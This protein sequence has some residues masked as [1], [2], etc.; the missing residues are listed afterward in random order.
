MPT[1]QYARILL[2]SREELLSSVAHSLLHIHEVFHIPLL[3]RERKPGEEESEFIL[4]E[5]RDG[6]RGE[7]FWSHRSKSGEPPRL[8]EIDGREYGEYKKKFLSLLSD[9]DSPLLLRQ[10]RGGSG[11]ENQSNAK[12]YLL[13]SSASEVRLSRDV[14]RSRVGYH[15][16]FGCGHALGAFTYRSS[17]SFLRSCCPRCE[18]RNSFCR[19]GSRRLS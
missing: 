9:P 2:W 3:C 8:K 1:L 16:Q 5:K 14:R 17:L 12:Q 18:A 11:S 15:L 7:G 19:T 10:I 6:S 4:F 13:H